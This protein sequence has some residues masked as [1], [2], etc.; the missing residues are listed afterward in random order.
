MNTQKNLWFSAI[1]MLLIIIIYNS[2]PR[3]SSS[4]MLNVLLI[5]S[6]FIFFMHLFLGIKK[7]LPKNQRLCNLILLVFS[8]ILMLCLLIAFFVNGAALHKRFKDCEDKNIT[9][10]DCSRWL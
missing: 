3:I 2:W 6:C 7:A 4:Y 10:D 5:I 9:I 1:T 8:F